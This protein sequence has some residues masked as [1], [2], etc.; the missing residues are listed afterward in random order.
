[1]TEHPEG[2]NGC[3]TERRAENIHVHTKK[4]AQTLR[5]IIVGWSFRNFPFSIH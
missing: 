4:G 1:M 5:N 3:V 2:S